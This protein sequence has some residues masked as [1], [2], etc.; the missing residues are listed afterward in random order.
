MNIYVLFEE[1][2]Q[3]S[4]YRIFLLRLIAMWTLTL[5]EIT[6]TG[7]RINSHYDDLPVIAF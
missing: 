6:P 2:R 5:P 3:G 4:E 7:K 1:K